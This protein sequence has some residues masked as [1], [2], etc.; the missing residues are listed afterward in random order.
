MSSHIKKPHV[1]IPAPS[2]KT[3]GDADNFGKSNPVN[4]KIGSLIINWELENGCKP[5][6]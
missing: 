2:Q 5:E 4:L 1:K 3:K 6:S